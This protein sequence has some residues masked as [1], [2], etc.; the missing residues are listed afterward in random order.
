MWQLLGHQSSDFLDKPLVLQMM[1]MHVALT[2]MFLFSEQKQHKQTDVSVI[3]LFYVAVCEHKEEE[4]SK[5][6][7]KSQN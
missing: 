4:R 3:W 7:V 1:L 5:S 6:G 2:V